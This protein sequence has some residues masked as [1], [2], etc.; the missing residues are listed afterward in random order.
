MN[1]EDF[2][3]AQ[4]LQEAAAIEKQIAEL[5]ERKK[6]LNEFVRIGLNLSGMARKSDLPAVVFGASKS[7]TSHTLIFHGPNK[8]RIEE[9]VKEILADGSSMMTRPLIEEL[10]KRN[11]E[12]GGKDK[13]L[14]LSAILSR[15]KEA[16]Q[17]DRKIGW[18][19]K[20]EGVESVRADID[21]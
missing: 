20:K 12:V 17:N 18:S 19:L 16:F 11:I 15:N 6:A 14:A 9:A 8:R 21:P 4:A 5:T 13:V 1:T 10:A 7:L 2:S 3:I